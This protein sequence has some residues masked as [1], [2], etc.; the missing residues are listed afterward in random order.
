M[1]LLQ[2]CGVNRC[3]CRIVYNSRR[4]ARRS[5]LCLRV[6]NPRQVQT[7]APTSGGEAEGDNTATQ[8]AVSTVF[9]DEYDNDSSTSSTG[10]SSAGGHLV[11]FDTSYPTGTNV[12]VE[13]VTVDASGTASRASSVPAPAVITAAVISTGGSSPPPAVPPAAV[14]AGLRR[15]LTRWGLGCA[16]NH[17]VGVGPCWRCRPCSLALH[18]HVTQDELFLN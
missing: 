5:H 12:T 18:V 14:D 17:L 8:G 9:S 6:A 13:L 11:V 10:T 15:S 4:P 3:A 1:S 16:L 2:Q 7:G